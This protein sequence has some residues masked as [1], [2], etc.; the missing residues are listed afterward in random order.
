MVQDVPI[1]D[2]YALINHAPVGCFVFDLTGKIKIVN[3]TGAAWLGEKQAK[4]IGGCFSHFLDEDTSEVFFDHLDIVQST[5]EAA[6][7][8]LTLQRKNLPPLSVQMESVLIEQ[9]LQRDE[10]PDRTCLSILSDVSEWEKR[11]LQY[12]TELADAHR[13]V[14]E[15]TEFLARLS[16]ELRSSLASMVGFADMLQERVEQE[17]RELAHLINTSGRHLLSTLN[18]VMDLARLEVLNDEIDRTLVD[19]VAHTRERVL[20][21]KPSAQQKNLEIDFTSTSDQVFSVLNDVFLDRILHNLID[22]A[23]KYTSD[24]RISVSVK[25]KER[26]VWINVTDTGLGIDET[27]LPILFTPFERGFTQAEHPSDGMGL[28]LAITKSL[29]ELMDGQIN[30]ASTEGE[31]TTFTVRFPLHFVPEPGY[32]AEEG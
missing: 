4:L 16:H 12:Q 9:E 5:S 6:C 28:G 24:G 27:F 8:R 21:L 15:K 20:I 10:K 13:S 29:V 22:N 11:E 31:G 1:T 19:V 14:R 7:C 26:H 2:S 30:V 3:P 23:V 32:P 17:N 25:I 18:A